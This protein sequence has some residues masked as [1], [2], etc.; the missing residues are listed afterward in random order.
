MGLRK[1]YRRIYSESLGLQRRI[2]RIVTVLYRHFIGGYRGH[3]KSLYGDY[4]RAIQTYSA[5]VRIVE[6]GIR[7]YGI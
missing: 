1:R 2:R 4:I 6:R 5:Y 3:T 7:M